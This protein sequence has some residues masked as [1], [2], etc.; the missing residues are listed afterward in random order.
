L[1]VN[2][3]VKDSFL[4]EV[5]AFIPARSGSKSIKNKNI[6]K[7]DGKPLFAHSIYHAKKSKLIKKII[8]SSDSL[9]YISIAKKFGCKNFHIRSKKI[10]SNTASEHS[11]FFDFIVKRLKKN[12]TLP[13]YFIHLRPTAPIRNISSINKAIKVFKRV[14]KRYTSLRTMTQMSN[15]AYRSFRIKSKKLSSIL[16]LDYDIDKYCI[17]RQFYDKTYFCNTVADIYLTT[18]ILKGKIFGNKVYPLITNDDYCDID[19][20]K[21]LN[22]AK[23]LIKSQR[24]SN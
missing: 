17:P 12:E 15:P 9:K 3:L 16:K 14:S 6:R 5:W 23:F 11:V 19:E 1:K 20:I 13:K 8:F 4:N 22:K 10:S 7:L 18:T 2:Q 24:K 21:D